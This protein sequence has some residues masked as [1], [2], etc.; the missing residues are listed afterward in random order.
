MSGFQ[1]ALS[2][3]LARANGADGPENALRA[4]TALA[5]AELGDH[6][7]AARPGML[8][9]GERDYRIS[10][11]FMIT[12]DRRYNML[13]ANVGFPAEQ[14][15]LSIPITWNHPGRVVETQAPVLLRN[16]DDHPEFRQFL[17][18]SRMGSSIYAPMIFGGVMHGQI[19]A[20]AQARTTYDDADL[21]K[22]VLLGHAAAAV[23]V[24]KGGPAW[25]AADYPPANQW[26]AEERSV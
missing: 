5:H 24:A 6:G 19:V 18:T 26:R 3:A 21:A 10:G 16:V 8:K 25:L 20:A 12:P 15:R 13:V 17:K 1:A 9:P 11:C 23:F 2:D 7:A 14:E 22:L 4:L